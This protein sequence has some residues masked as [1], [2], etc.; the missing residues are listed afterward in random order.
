MM[1]YRWIAHWEDKIM[2]PRREGTKGLN[3][4]ETGRQLDTGETY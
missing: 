3:T 2:W 1:K 4:N